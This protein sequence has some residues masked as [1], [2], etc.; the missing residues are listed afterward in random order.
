[1]TE[2][3]WFAAVASHGAV[4]ILGGSGYVGRALTAA[5]AADGVQ[6]W[7]LTRGA[8]LGGL[9]AGAKA[10]TWLPTRGPDALGESIAG[11]SA[12]VNLV[13]ENIG[14]ERWSYARRQELVESR[15][16][17]THLL[18]SA[19]A[20]LDHDDRPAV[21][22]SASGID[23][24]GNRGDDT[25][26]EKDK[27]GSTFLALLCVGWEAAAADAGDLGVRV[28]RLRTG[29]VLSRDS[30]ALQRFVQPFR[31]FVGGRVGSGR[32]WVSWIH[33]DDLVGLYR[34]AIEDTQLTGPLNAVGPEP[35]REEDMADLIG[36]LVHRPDFLPVPAFAVRTVLGMQADLAL[37][38]RRAVPEV[39]IQQGYEFRYPTLED[40]LGEALA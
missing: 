32:Q 13:G 12:V 17:S 33:L 14:A 37:H 8:A 35:R 27:P 29:L 40:A 21:L 1:M 22:A 26:T 6:V 5:L 19:I 23:Y 9:P 34:L 16:K 7:V 25:V 11:A 36:R 10:V 30:P 15:T 38:G 20:G 3:V 18:V 2:A 31:Y 24:Y 39:A 28:V 4:A